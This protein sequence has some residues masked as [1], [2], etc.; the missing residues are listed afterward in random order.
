MT[1]YSVFY[2]RLGYGRRTL[3]LELW[4]NEG[5]G[6][7]LFYPGSMFSPYQYREL[8]NALR[9]NGLTVAALHLTG[10]GCNS[11]H[12]TF[13]FDDLLQ[14]GLDAEG[15]L[16]QQGYGPLSVCGHSQGG[17]LALAHASIS[18]KLRLAFPITGILPQQ[19]EALTLTRFIGCRN[20]LRFQKGIEVLACCLPRLPIPLPVY[21]SIKR[22]CANACHIRSNRR[23]GR[24][25]YPLGFLAS[26][27][28]AHVNPVMNC[29]VYLFNALDD[30][31]FTSELALTTFTLLQAPHKRLIWLPNGGHLA[32]LNP[33]IALFTAKHI[34]AAC[35]GHGLP[36]HVTVSLQG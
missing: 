25:S 1:H 13:T 33:H 23:R 11:Y 6:S 3:T 19:K 10:H 17:I 8:L 36:L 29:P 4:P 22:I 21:L 14:N 9:Q 34:A 32:V 7:V 26:L 35:A 18:D 5:A 31:L 28:K 16:L 20:R 2:H 30:A 15:W 12:T 27:F 24:L